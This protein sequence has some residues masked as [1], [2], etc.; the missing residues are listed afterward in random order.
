MTDLKNIGTQKIC[1]SCRR[2][3]SVGNMK[4]YVSRSSGKKTTSLRCYLCIGN[5]TSNKL[6]T[7]QKKST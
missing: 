6:A 1:P 5:K 4:T 7:M 3:T 2:L